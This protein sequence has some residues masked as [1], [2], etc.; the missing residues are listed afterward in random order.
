MRDIKFRAWNNENEYMI[1]SKQ[2]VFTALQ[3]CM[4]ITRQDDGYYNNG[5]LLK[6][7]KG[8]YTLMQFT[9]LYDKNGKGIYEGDIISNGT[10]KCL[11]VWI[12]EQAGF[13][14]K[15]LN[16]EFENEEWTNPMID[17]RKDDEVI[18]NIY[19]NKNLLEE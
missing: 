8:K 7:N 12:K 13:M 2:G 17:L 19:D 6:P 10:E 9:G 16:E 18:G 5:D 11:V 1:T 14:L 15:L 3:S 4:N